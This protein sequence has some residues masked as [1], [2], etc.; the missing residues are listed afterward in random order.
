[1]VA[2]LVLYLRTV[3]SSAYLPLAS[4]D[5]PPRVPKRVV[6]VAAVANQGLGRAWPV[7]CLHPYRFGRCSDP[8]PPGSSWGV[9]RH[10]AKANNDRVA[11]GFDDTRSL[12]LAGFGTRPD[13]AWFQHNSGES[14]VNTWAAATAKA[15]TT[16]YAAAWLAPLGGRSGRFETY[17]ESCMCSARDGICHRRRRRDGAAGGT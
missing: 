3:V 17:Y 2:W 11:H 12:I 4:A 14:A 1:M 13:P 8:T 6:G 7:V 10:R 15:A 9:A 5:T 16:P